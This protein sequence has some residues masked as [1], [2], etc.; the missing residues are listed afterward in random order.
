MQ[1]P[2]EPHLGERIEKVVDR[3]DAFHLRLAGPN[4]VQMPVEAPTSAA[5]RAVFEGWWRRGIDSW[6]TR[7]GADD[8]LP[9]ACELGPPPYAIT[10][11][12]GREMTDRWA[13]AIALKDLARRL[14]AEGRDQRTQ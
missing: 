3:C 12:S 8:H 7:A 6:L 13:E 4:Q 1:L 2:I 9:I 14:F 5:W 10:D 11:P